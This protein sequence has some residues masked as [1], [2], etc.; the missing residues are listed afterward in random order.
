MLGENRICTNCWFP[1]CTKSIAYKNFHLHSTPRNKP[2]NFAVATSVHENVSFVFPFRP[3]DQAC[4]QDI[5]CDRA[6][7]DVV[8]SK[9]GFAAELSRTLLKE[10]K[11]GWTFRHSKLIL[12]LHTRYGLEIWYAHSSSSCFKGVALDFYLFFAQK[13]KQSKVRRD[14]KT[15]DLLCNNGRE[16]QF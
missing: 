11:F 12:C 14:G 10:F 16:K 8:S 5:M 1:R 7:P 6:E 3:R 9:L 4:L 15:V 2:Y 13:I